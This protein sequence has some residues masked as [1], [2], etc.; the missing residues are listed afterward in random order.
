MP[1]SYE[2]PSTLRLWW[3]A[4]R[5]KTLLAAAAPV[6]VGLACAAAVA[7]LQPVGALLTLLGA[8]L[9][10]V[11][12]N[13]ANDVFDFEK[14][15]DTTERMGPTRAVQAGWVTPQVMRR[16]LA[17]TLLSS[18]VVGVY[19]VSVAG[20]VLVVIGVSSMVAAVA[21]TGG[22]YPL[23][24]HGLG[25]V[26]VMIFFGF[27]AVCGTAYV[28]LGAVPTLAW[29]GSV[30]VG[31]LATNILVV[32][33]VRDIETD[34]KAGKRTL[35][36]RFGRRF[37]VL[38]YRVLLS[39]AY[40][41]PVFLLAT[42][43]LDAWALLPWLTLP[44]GLSLSRRLECDTGSELNATLAGSARLLFLF[45]AALSLAIALGFNR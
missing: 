10:Q 14:G 6:A 16:A 23:G 25:D 38:E 31:C 30:P 43:Q 4:A 13:F 11:A 3:L 19:L 9:L 15:A 17:L 34:I 21:Y 26:F 27:V 37:G 5:P 32:N 18:L 20:P 41:A 29:V 45:G 1:P 36:V 44:F 28:Q 22:P 42:R 2:R 8:L 24:Y 7:P 33:N 12:A 35:P 40:A 39:I